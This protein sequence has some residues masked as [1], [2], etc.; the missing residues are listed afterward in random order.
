MVLP[1]VVAL[2]LI[3]AGVQFLPFYWDMAAFLMEPNTRIPFRE[4]L[5]Q[6]PLPS[7]AAAAIPSWLAILNLPM[8]LWR[9]AP[10]R[11]L[12][13][14]RSSVAIGLISTSVWGQLAVR[15][16]E[17]RLWG[18]WIAV[19]AAAM[20]ALAGIVFIARQRLAPSEPR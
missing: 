13:A 5:F 8:L 6:Y 12:W 4:I 1:I 19:A 9:R 7:V 15:Y 2:H 18:A 16:G 10:G 11:E 3:V 20:L 17:S 14:A